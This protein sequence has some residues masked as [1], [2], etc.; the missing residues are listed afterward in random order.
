MGEFSPEQKAKGSAICRAARP[1]G[2]SIVYSLLSC[3][4]SF[5]EVIC[6]ACEVMLFPKHERKIIQK[7]QMLVAGGMEGSETFLACLD[8]PH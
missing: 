8:A 5:V 3:L 2:W 7:S 4:D 1:L 6:G